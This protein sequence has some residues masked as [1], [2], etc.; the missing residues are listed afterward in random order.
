MPWVG[1]RWLAQDHRA[2][3]WQ[4]LVR[5]RSSHLLFPCPC[6]HKHSFTQIHSHTDTHMYKHSDGHTH[7]HTYNG[8]EKVWQRMS[9]WGLWFLKKYLFYFYLFVWLP[10][11]LLAACGLSLWHG[12]SCPVACDV[13]VPQPGFEPTSPALQGRISTTGLLGKSWGW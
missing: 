3:K 1:H 2:S 4:C 5:V 11:V 6:L 8:E 12:P 7:K 9:G 13:L 10:P